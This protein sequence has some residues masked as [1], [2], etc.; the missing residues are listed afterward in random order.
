MLVWLL[1]IP[2]FVCANLIAGAP[3]AEPVTIL[4]K[5]VL[6]AILSEI[7]IAGLLQAFTVSRGFCVLARQVVKT[8]YG[9]QH[10]GVVHLNQTKLLYKL[11][12]L[13]LDAGTHGCVAKTSAALQASPDFVCIESILRAKFGYCIKY[14]HE[15]MAKFC[16]QGTLP[17][18][19]EDGRMLSALPY[20]IDHSSSDSEWIYFIRGLVDRGHHAILAQLTFANISTGRFYK[21]MSV[22]AP[23]ALISA[24]ITALQRAEP[25]SGLS[26]LLAAAESGSGAAAWLQ[27]GKVPL[28]IL[29]DLHEKSISIPESL[30]LDDGLCES[31]MRF[32]L[33]VLG[34]EAKEAEELLQFV[35]EH[36]GDEAK[37]LASVFFGPMLSSVSKYPGRDVFQAVLT[38]LRF[39]PLCNEHITRNYNEMI[40]ALPGMH[41]HTA[42]AFLDCKQYDLASRCDFSHLC[43]H[44]LGSLIGKLHQLEGFR[45]NFLLR[46]LAEHYIGAAKLLKHMVRIKAD[47]ACAQLIWDSIQ[48]ATR[49]GDFED[50]CCSVPLSALRRLMHEPDISRCTVQEILGT[51]TGFRWNQDSISKEAHALYTAMFWEAPDDIIEYLLGQISTE[52]PLYHPSIWQLMVAT[53]YSSRLCWKFLSRFEAETKIWAQVLEFRPDLIKE[54]DS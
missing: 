12:A 1:A 51:L 6:L 38:R 25:T 33:Y 19:F 41:Y 29:R 37:C 54:P 9:I 8:F 22:A 44:Q 14:A 4:P 2:C 15:G 28:F 13:M 3:L 30:L 16:L 20:I 46:K 23:E 39:S 18:A 50:Y 11:D 52:A 24:A 40:E 35:F 26:V 17:S 5:E 21:L 34:K 47:D 10:N 53:K 7:G 42:C 32:W 48:T 45:P 43:A 31:S 49:Y 27:N 36:G